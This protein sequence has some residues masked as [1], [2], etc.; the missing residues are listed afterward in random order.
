L[1]SHLIITSSRK[2]APSVRT[3]MRDLHALIPG[4][5]RITRGKLGMQGLADAAARLKAEYILMIGSSRGGID[6]L[7]FY[8]VGGEG[9]TLI[10]PILYVRGY[11]LRRDYAQTANRPRWRPS[12][13]VILQPQ[14]PDLQRLA[15][16]LSRIFKVELISEGGPPPTSQVF[17][18]FCEGHRATRLS[19]FSS[20]D[21]VEIGPSITL[22]L[23]SWD[24]K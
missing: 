10:P 14:N 19:F 17:I 5:F 16:A 3:M 18:Q 2:P 9:L 22:R 24:V 8:Q 20:R 4:S 7:K 23:V 11:R 21:N 6:S 15:E 1:T 13:T 12:K